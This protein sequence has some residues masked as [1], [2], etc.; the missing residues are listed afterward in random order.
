[1]YTVHEAKKKWVRLKG[2]IDNSISGIFQTLHFNNGYNY[3]EY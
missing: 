2:K 1:M 3:T